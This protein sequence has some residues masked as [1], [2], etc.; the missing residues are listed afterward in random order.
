MA[1]SLYINTKENAAKIVIDGNEIGDVISYILLENSKE[2][3][4]T[5]KIVI[6]GEIEVQR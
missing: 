5:L 6:T 3:T 4:L 2:V 1:K